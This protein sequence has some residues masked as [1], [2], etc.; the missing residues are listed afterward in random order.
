MEYDRVEYSVG[1]TS[2]VR[3]YLGFKVHPFHM[4]PILLL[5]ITLCLYYYIYLVIGLNKLTTAAFMPQQG[6]PTHITARL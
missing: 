2:A 6:A 5:C 4:P 1:Q 3:E